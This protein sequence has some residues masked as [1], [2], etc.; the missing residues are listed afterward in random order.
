MTLGVLDLPDRGFMPAALGVREEG[1][2]DLDAEE[3]VEEDFDEDGGWAIFLLLFVW[4][5]GVEGW[6][7]MWL[8][9]FLLL[10]LLWLNGSIEDLFA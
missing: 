6:W 9:W 1:R 10:L 4:F 5:G 7:L 2:W 8:M 3:E